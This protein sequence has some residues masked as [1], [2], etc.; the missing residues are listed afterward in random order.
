MKRLTLLFTF[1]ALL[2]CQDDVSKQCYSCTTRTFTAANQTLSETVNEVC[3]QT[4]AD[5][6]KKARTFAATA[7]SAGSQCSCQKK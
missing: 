3:G 2:G 7:T 5:N 1:V 4:E 6:H